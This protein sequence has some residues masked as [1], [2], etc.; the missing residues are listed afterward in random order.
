MARSM[1]E[2]GRKISFVEEES[3]HGLMGESTT[4]SGRIISFM[5]LVSTHG[6]MANV[7]QA[8]T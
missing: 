8:N 5:D 7:I 1:K 4:V 2:T 6:L 3:T